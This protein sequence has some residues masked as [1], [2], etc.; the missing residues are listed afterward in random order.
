MQGDAS[1]RFLREIQR[2]LASVQYL[3]GTHLPQSLVEAV[4]R[5]PKP[6]WVRA[7]PMD[8]TLLF[9]DVS[10]F[11]ALS[12]RLASEGRQGI[13]RL[14]DR[15]NAHFE[16]MVEILIHSGG[17]LMKYAGDAMLAYFPAL[18]GARQAQW[19]VRA[20]HRM[21]RA[22]ADPSGGEVVLRMKV[23]IAT[24]PFYALSVGTARRMEYVLLGETVT[25]TLAAEKAATAG[26]VLVDAPTGSCLAPAQRGSSPAPGFRVAGLGE[27][28][29]GDFEIRTGGRRRSRSTVSWM[30]GRA[31]IVEQ[32]AAT[33]RQV[34]VLTAYLPTV[35]ARRI[36]ATMDARHLPGENRPVAVLFLHVRGIDPEGEGREGA[37][38]SPVRL[39]SDYFRTV[40]RIVAR[41]EG[42][43]SRVDPYGDGSKFLILFGAPVAHEDDPRRAVRAALEIDAGLADLRRRWR[44]LVDP[45]EVRHQMG[46]A[47]GPTFAGQVGTATHREYTVMGDDV[48]LAARLMAAAA[49]GQLLASDAVRVAVG[50]H[51]R[52]E[53]LPP[54]R[55]RGKA[56]PLDVWQV[57]ALRDDPLARRVRDRGPLVGRG[58]EWKRAAAV[59]EVA[60]AG[61][62]TRLTI[63]GEAGVGKSHLADALAGFALERG[64]RVLPAASAAYLADTPYATWA[65]LVETAAGIQHGDPQAVRSEKLEAVLDALG[66]SASA[67]QFFN[68]LGLPRR[69]DAMRPVRTGAAAPDDGGSS[70][71]A[72]NLFNRLSRAAG[73]A[74]EGGSSLWDLARRR[75][76]GAPVEDPAGEVSGARSG[77]WQRLRSQVRTRAR[78]RLFEAV[79]DL[80]RAMAGRAPLVLVFEDAQWMDAPSR[81]LLDAA[82]GRLAGAPLLL[83]EVARGLEAEGGDVLFLEPL[84]LAGTTA[85]IAQLLHDTVA[86]CPPAQLADAVHPLT[87]GNPLFIQEIVRW[88]RRT[89]WSQIDR[90]D[91]GLR[92]S[93]MLQEL[94][95]S[96]LDALPYAVGEAARAAAV[97]GEVVTAAALAPLLGAPD[98]ALRDALGQLQEAG[99]LLPLAGGEG[100]RSR[101]RQPLV[102]EMVYDSVPPGRRAAR[103]MRGPWRCWPPTSAGRARTGMPPFIC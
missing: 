47:Y 78:A 59:L 17:Q 6:G 23:G 98:D 18:D 4:A 49:P 65:A 100:G 62:G 95:L 85:L 39:L 45:P 19:A 88:L 68:L 26:Q 2:R 76:E 83:L 37:G 97:A 64:A 94:V 75:R 30:S 13:E 102:R 56:A 7:H 44:H 15:L 58:A 84:G 42:V 60:L 48:N 72:P 92:A 87:G 32:L 11:T 12:E 89:H 90:L 1:L 57:E 67:P 66:Q 36:I 96:R 21:L 93:R 69:D 71:E 9:A 43:V 91:A 24:G 74:T 22:L 41:Y 10:G 51:A 101:F 5:D 52:F 14:T 33:L 82:A 28:A 99:W 46:L 103:R 77:S 27:E 34:E 31:E 20:G 73:T 55:V 79:L 3:L 54:M 80:L 25:R 29:L 61:R 81:T 8:G 16:R 38:G 40:Q 50:A 86:P 70:R 63:R 35:L 53:A